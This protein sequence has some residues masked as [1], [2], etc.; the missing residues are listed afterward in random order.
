MSNLAALRREIERMKTWTKEKRPSQ[1][2]CHFVEIVQGST[3]TEGQA[4]ILEANLTCFEQNHDH[5]GF[6]FIEVP[7]AQGVR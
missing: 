1:C 2:V 5:T 6:T 7:A 4:K 3:L